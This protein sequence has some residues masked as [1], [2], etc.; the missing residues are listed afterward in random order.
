MT[1]HIEVPAQF[2]FSDGDILLN[3]EG[4]PT[5]E[6]TKLETIGEMRSMLYGIATCHLTR[7]A[8]QPVKKP[9]PANPE[10]RTANVMDQFQKFQEDLSNRANQLRQQVD[11]QHEEILKNHAS[12][13]NPVAGGA[14]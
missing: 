2:V 7:A 12:T 6:L 3:V 10:A 13:I 5:L 14:K 8:E 9:S 11:K 4:M 1:F